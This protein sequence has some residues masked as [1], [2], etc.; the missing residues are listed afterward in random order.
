[1]PNGPTVKVTSGRL[2]LMPKAIGSRHGFTTW[3]AALMI[4]A[5]VRSACRRS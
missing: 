2:Q 1:M 3:P 5:G 4:G